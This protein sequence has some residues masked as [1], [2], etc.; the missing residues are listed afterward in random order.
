MLARLRLGWRMQRW[1]LAVLVG[2]TLVLAV[3]MS[4]VA[5]QLDLSRATLI[6]CYEAEALSASCRATIEWGNL[7]AGA[8]GLLGAAATVAPF[9]VGIFLGAP[10]VAREIEHRTAPIAWTLS[11]SRRR[12]LVGRSLP[13]LVL[14]GVVLLAVG[15]ASELLH[16]SIEEGELGFRHYGMVGPLIAARGLAVFAIGVLVGLALGRVLPALLVT[17]LATVALVGAMSV[18]RDLLMREE[19]VWV[20]MGDQAEVVHMVYDQAFRTDSGEII[21]YEQAYEQFPDM[22]NEFG[23]GA[24]P[25]TISVWRIVPPEA[26]GVYVAREIG[27]LAIVLVAVAA[28]SVG[29]VAVRR[30][31]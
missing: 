29:L 15:Q 31:E 11:L 9:V 1:E 5:W 8:I 2:G 30:P 28:G 19:S 16:S 7:L 23:E 14:I 25:G 4:L 6:A 13:L 17:M 26:Y 3:G 10:L 18:G 20:P 12:W 27:V 22:F 24:P 21:T